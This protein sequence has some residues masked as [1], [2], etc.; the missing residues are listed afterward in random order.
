MWKQWNFRARAQGRGSSV[1]EVD[2]APGT[3]EPP[4]TQLFLAPAYQELQTMT[5][6]FIAGSVL[7]R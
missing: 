3:E 1:E 7:R 4:K 2:A 6:L 5:C